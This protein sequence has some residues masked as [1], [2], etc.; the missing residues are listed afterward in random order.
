VQI[1]THRSRI[2]ILAVDDHPLLRDGIAALIGTQPD[3]H[4][5]AEAASAS[6]A[7]EKFRSTCPDVTLMDIQMPGTNGIDAIAAIRAERPDARIIVL[8]TYAGDALAERALRAGVQGY[9]LKGSVRKELLDAIRKVH[10]GLKRIQPEVAAELAGCLGEEGLSARE[11]EVLALIAAGKANK[12]IAA[13]LSI[14]EETTKGHVKNILAKLRAND[15][16][17]A[18]TLALRRGII[19]I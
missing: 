8:T 14:T 13:I 17:H 5:V 6:E 10:A 16:T 11:L 1:N 15:R 4:L 18:V 19:Q 3:M 12:S 2:R 7:L 9:L